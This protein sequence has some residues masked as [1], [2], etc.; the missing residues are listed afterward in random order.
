MTAYRN[1]VRH[2]TRVV[3]LGLALL[4]F[5]CAC[6]PFV[7]SPTSPAMETTEEY[8]GVALAVPLPGSGIRLP[9]VARANRDEPPVACPQ[10][11]RWPVP[12]GCSAI[13]TL[14]AYAEMRTVGQ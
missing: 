9:R 2:G 14:R 13:C 7:S 12:L 8:R 10:E 1:E 3:W 6:D 11:C 5:R 4:P